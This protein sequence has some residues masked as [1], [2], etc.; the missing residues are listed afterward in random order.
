MPKLLTAAVVGGVFLFLGLPSNA[1]RLPPPL[2]P[3]PLP[4]P[5]SIPSSVTTPSLGP[6]DFGADVAALQRALDRNGIDPGPI[7]GDYGPMTR[8]AVEEFQQLYDLPVTGVAGPDT[9]DILGL[10]TDSVEVVEVVV[11]DDGGEVQADDTP[12]VAAVI[13]STSKLGEVRRSFGNA[14]VDYARQGEFINIGR[15]DS[16]SDAVSRVREARRLGFE[17]RIL[18]QR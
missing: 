11:V 2:E 17:A 6:G 9:L 15:Y 16:Y 8:A 4:S 7:D 10:N 1:Q 18:Y 14:V 5:S 13:E 12:Y 3:P